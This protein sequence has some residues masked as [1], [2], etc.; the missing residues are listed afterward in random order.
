MKKRRRRKLRIVLPVVIIAAAAGIA[1]FLAAFYVSNEDTEVM[2]STR[3]K[4]AEIR[5]IAM[6]SF[7]DHNSV[8]LRL[9]RKNI[10]VEGVPFL[11]SID[12]EAVSRDHIRLHVNENFPVGYLVQDGY[13][14]YF[15]ASG[16]VIEKLKDDGNGSAGEQGGEAGKAVGAREDGSAAESGSASGEESVSAVSGSAETASSDEESETRESAKGEG[17]KK[18]IEKNAHTEFRPALTDISEVTGITDEPVEV[19]TVLPSESGEL[20]P[21]LLALGKLI[22]KLEIPPD[23]I[24]IGEGETVTLHYDKAAVALGGS[25]L[26][27][28]KMARTAAILPQLKG[29]EGILH[30]EGLR[31]DTINIIFEQTDEESVRLREASLKPEN[32]V[33]EPAWSPDE[34]EESGDGGTYPEDEVYSEDEVAGDGE[35]DPEDEV[36]TE[37]EGYTENSDEEWTEA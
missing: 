17:G 33:L 16:T 8:Y 18:D 25:D 22:N 2:G 3:Y 7:I 5:R 35:T 4:D 14:C 31:E 12:V 9:F 21:T 34:D 1:G 27:E 6:P 20:Y 15:D 24:E 29:L 36:Y 19:G 26:L 13:R 37:D 28:E 10:P 30:L 23:M 11:S 32:S